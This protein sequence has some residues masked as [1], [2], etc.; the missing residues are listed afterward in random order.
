[1]ETIAPVFISGIVTGAIYST[2]GMGVVAIYKCT[3]VLNFAQGELVLLGAYL[4]WTFIAVLGLPIW[5]GILAGLIVTAVCGALVQYV[6][7]RPLIGQPLFSVIV[8][9]VGLSWLLRGAIFSGWGVDPL[10]DIAIFPDTSLSIGNVSIS[11]AELGTLAIC[12]ILAGGFLAFF[13]YS[14][15]GV[16]MRATSEDSQAAQALNINVSMVFT[17]AWAIGALIAGAGGLLLATKSIFNIHLAPLGIKSLAVVFLGGLESF[18]G[19]F[20]AGITIGLA[21]AIAA[22]YLDPVVG[23]GTKEVFAYVLIVFIL[24][25]RPYGFAGEKEIERV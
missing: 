2:I 1:M 5:I 6:F 11:A 20:L 19:T 22:Y 23:G 25:F 16:R 3:R 12:L 21:E 8:L 14:N 24:L 4:C 9:T 15:F 17:F 18:G 13:K 10:G 7:I